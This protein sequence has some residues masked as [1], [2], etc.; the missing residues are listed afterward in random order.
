MS[1]FLEHTNCTACG[2]SDALALYADGSH[3]FSCGAHSSEGSPE[4]A[5]VKVP[6]ALIDYQ[7]C[8][9]HLSLPKRKISQET[10]KKYNY[11]VGYHKGTF[12]HIATHYDKNK[13]VCAQKL[14]YP[15][16]SFPWRGDAKAATLFGQQ[17]FEPNKNISVLITEGPLD[18]LSIAEIQGCKWPVVSLK[19]GA[20]GAKKELEEQ[21]EWLNGFKEIRL[22]LDNDKE[23]Q[24]AIE[25]IIEIPFEAG[26]LK[27]VKLPLKDASDM[28]QAGRVAELQNCL[29]AAQVHRPDTITNAADLDIRELFKSEA[30]GLMTPYTEFNSVVRG[31]FKERL[32]I[33]TAGWGAGK[34]TF[35]KE[36]AY[37]IG[38]VHKKKVGCIYLEEGQLDRALGFVSIHTNVSPVYMKEHPEEAIV[39]YDAVHEELYN[40]D[41]TFEIYDAKGG[42]ES[43][44]LLNQVEYMAA[45]M[46]CEYII[47][48]H[49]TYIVS[50]M[51]GHNE[52]DRKMIDLL[53]N[54]LKSISLRTKC[55]IITAVQLRKFNVG[56][57]GANNGAVIDLQD[58]K[59][60]GEL[61]GIAD[62]VLALEGDGQ[63]E[64]QGNERIIRVL[65]NRT[66]GGV[67]GTAGVLEYSRTTGRLLEKFKY[68]SDTEQVPSSGLQL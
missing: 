11:R 2:S 43:E 16:K 44:R 28:L 57:K 8:F 42:L 23:G 25:E 49:I 14:R 46:G 22:C 68:H 30:P 31:I 20:Q 61:S 39:H 18:A 55:S 3:C 59:G 1:Q 32:M 4:V 9:V 47:L 38:H 26:K 33:V 24:K 34:S 53:L 13:N 12:V 36:I 54:R 51:T 27:V 60:S 37:H 15:D 6:S 21:F 40:K 64:T 29:W 41:R 65:K 52:G 58:L 19:G 63:S 10:C 35:L 17:L 50:G 66:G 67:I 7:E 62:V 5:K 56:S 48:D 45:A